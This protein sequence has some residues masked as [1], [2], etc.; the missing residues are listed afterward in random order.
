MSF[1]RNH[2]AL[3]AQASD[4]IPDAKAGVTVFLHGCILHVWANPRPVR[5]KV[6]LPGRVFAVC[7]DLP[8]RRSWQVWA[9]LVSHLLPCRYI[10]PGRM[11]VR[12]L[13]FATSVGWEGNGATPTQRTCLKQ[14]V[15]HG[16]AQ[17]RRN[18]VPGSLTLSPTPISCRRLRTPSFWQ[19]A[20]CAGRA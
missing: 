3:L 11:F 6:A 4:K 5:A 9:G 12:L 19:D 7:L 16:D 14:Y 17:S 10:L 2:G 15:W 18:G 1:A 8:F 20:A 13:R